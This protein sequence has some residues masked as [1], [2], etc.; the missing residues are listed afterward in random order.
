MEQSQVQTQKQQQA[1][2]QTTSVNQMQLLQSRLAELPVTQ[3]ADCIK[4]EMDD[5]PALEA[6]LPEDHSDEHEDTFD[7][8]QDDE[9]DD[10]ETMS[11]REERQSQLD[12]ALNNLGMDDEELPVFNNRHEGYPEMS[13]VQGETFYDSLMMQMMETE[14]TPRQKEIMEYIIGSLDE[15][16][17]LRKSTVAIADELAI[18]NDIDVNQREIEQVLKKLQDFDPAGIGA[19]SLKECLMIQINR[20]ENTY[21]KNLMKRVLNEFYDEFTKKHWKKIQ[22]ELNIDDATAERLCEEMRR[23]NPKPGSSLGDAMGAETIHQITPDVYIDTHE[24][25]TISF[26]LNNSDIPELTITP[27]F[28][29]MVRQDQGNADSMSRQMR[30]ALLYAR[31]KVD[32]AQRFIDAIKIR[33]NTLTITVRAIIHW[34]R[35]FFE[36]GDD[37]SLRPMKLKDIA[38]KTGLDISTV[39][40]VC[41]GKYAQT[42]WGIFPF[43]HFFSDSYVTDDGKEMSTKSIKAALEELIR[44][45]DK[46]NPINDEALARMMAERGFPIARR[47]VAKYREMMGFPVARMRKE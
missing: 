47:T 38:E 20:R 9:Q 36:D 44:G 40:R 30:E 16:G 45:E 11:E 3:L 18:Y 21:E 41:N 23:L 13:Y 37:T 32:L 42:R 17:W 35:Q 39:S 28:L 27:S 19:R 7:D 14:L 1:L 10:F 43:R 31:N 33:R 4:T 25:G 46:K 12:D 5:N 22:R 8:T 2:K 15:D 24:D 29:D 26:A 6:M 34:Q